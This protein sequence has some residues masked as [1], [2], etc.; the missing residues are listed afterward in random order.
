MYAKC[1]AQSKL[2]LPVSVSYYPPPSSPALIC[3]F[4]QDLHHSKISY[5]GYYTHPHH[6]CSVNVSSS[7]VCKITSLEQTLLCIS[8]FTQH[9]PN[10]MIAIQSTSRKGYSNALEQACMVSQHVY[11]YFKPQKLRKC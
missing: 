2:L 6:N 11:P 4:S 9:R 1:L 8:Y 10:H 5:S 3:S 7:T